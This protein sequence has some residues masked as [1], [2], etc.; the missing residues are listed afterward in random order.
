MREI[1]VILEDSEERIAPMRDRL[2]ASFSEWSYIFFNNAPDAIAWLKGRVQD[3]AL[4]S[5][6]RD[7]GP[8]WQRDGELFDPGVGR[9]VVDYLVTQPPQCPVIIHSSNSDAAVGMEMALAEHSWSVERVIPFQHL[10]SSNSAEWIDRD[11]AEAIARLLAESRKR[12]ARPKPE[13]RE[14]PRARMIIVLEDSKP[15][16]DLTRRQLQEVL[17]AR[18]S[19]RFNNAFELMA[20]LERHLKDFSSL[21]RNRKIVILDN[22]K[23]RIGLMRRKLDELFPERSAVFFDNTPE[24]IAWLEENLEECDLISLD[25]NLGPSWT[26]EGERFDPGTGRDVVDYLAAKPPQ[27]PII[28]HSSRS[29]ADI[30]MEIGLLES[31]WIFERVVHSKDLRWIETSWLE[32]AKLLLE[33][34][35]NAELTE[36]HIPSPDAKWES[37]SQFA[38]SFNGYQYWGKALECIEVGDRC[39]EIYLAEGILPKSLAELRAGLLVERNRWR[40][41]GAEPSEEAI[42]YMQ[43][44][45]ESIRQWV[46]RSPS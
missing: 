32:M 28:F 6:D 15:C 20:W 3:C 33:P 25:Y 5:L 31:Q 29:E 10:Y 46:K 23:K 43:A 22:S 7:L 26:R 19:V 11:W 24:A 14:I 2:E 38:L 9:D 1:I 27:C 37:I 4:I 36:D 17:P 44:I 30:S 13:E 16:W 35:A 45:L 41:Y 8:S 42:A 40:R 21:Q 39:A 18:E 12:P 34:I